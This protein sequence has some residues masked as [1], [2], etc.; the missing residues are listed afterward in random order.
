MGKGTPARLVAVL[1][2]LWLAACA[3]APPIADNLNRWVG[4][5]INGLISRLGPPDRVYTMPNG[6]RLYSYS[7]SHSESMPLVKTPTYVVPPSTTVRISGGETH[8]TTSGG[9]IFGGEVYGGGK[10]QSWCNL[11]L[12]VNRAHRI[13]GWSAQGN[14]CAELL[15]LSAPAP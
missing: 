3:S 7:R 5:D 10:Y 15:P 11:H 2:P 6:N 8:V 12:E 9:E 4:R 14:A 1:L 13:L